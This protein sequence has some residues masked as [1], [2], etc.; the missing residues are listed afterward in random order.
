MGFKVSRNS[1]NESKH[2]SKT[3]EL[4]SQNLKGSALAT[5]RQGHAKCVL[6]V[7]VQGGALFTASRDRTATGC[8][9]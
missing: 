9:R 7:F 2:S 4:E 8:I 6:S 3:R 1:S 5:L